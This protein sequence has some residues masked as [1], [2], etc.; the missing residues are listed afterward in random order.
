MENAVRGMPERGRIQEVKD[1]ARQMVFAHPNHRLGHELF[2][3][4][5][6]IINT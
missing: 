3:Y 1:I 5:K 2:K 4:L 6:R